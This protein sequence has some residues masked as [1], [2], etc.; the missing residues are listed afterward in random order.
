MKNKKTLILVIVCVVA[1]FALVAALRLADR[2]A[3]AAE[4]AAKEAA[5]TAVIQVNTVS[6]KRG[7]LANEMDFVGGVSSSEN[8]AV[9]PKMTAKVTDLRVKAGDTVEAGQVL[10][11]MDTSDLSSQVDLVNLALESA[12]TSYELTTLYSLDAQENSA[13][14]QYDQARDAYES[15]DDAYDELVKDKKKKIEAMEA[16]IL[17]AQGPLEDYIALC[18]PDETLTHQQAMLK[19]QQEYDIANKAWMTAGCPTGDDPAYKAMNE[20]K[21]RL[22]TLSG[23]MEAYDTAVSTLVTYKQ[24]ISQASAGRDAAKT[25]YNAA[26][27]GHDAV[28]GDARILQ[29]DLA[30]MQV[31]QAQINHASLMDQLNNATVTAPVSGQV[32]SVSV[33]ENNYATPSAAAI[34]LGSTDAM[35]VTFGLPANYFGQVQVGDTA[36]VEANGKTAAATVTEIAP[37]LNAQTGTFNVTAEFSAVEGLLPGAMARVTL[38]T[39]HAENVLTLPVDCVRFEENKP[40]VYL[41]KEG[42]AQKT[43][44]QLGMTDENCYEVVS[45]LTAA[46]RVI[47]TWHPNL[48]DGAAVAVQ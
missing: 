12:Q 46:D 10:F 15:A 26:K 5:A 39:Q 8:V 23:L 30:A 2:N 3:E 35:K 14:L 45:G 11:V 19:A 24:A 29:E 9:L 48:A 6:P 20:T 27:V 34:V 42:F 4:Q 38:V 47:S 16:G 28:S 25:G 7:D 1:L 40:Y 31:R 13:Y 43:F 32:L 17:A 41:E 44:I 33:Q 36:A 18:W 37:M 21:D 22:N